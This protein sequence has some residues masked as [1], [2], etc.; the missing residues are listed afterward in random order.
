MPESRKRDAKERWGTTRQ[1]N[2]PNPNEITAPEN[3]QTGLTRKQIIIL[4]VVA[5]LFAGAIFYVVKNR[6]PRIEET[7]SGLQYQDYRIGDGPQPQKG[8]TVVVDYEGRLQR[9]NTKFDSSY[10]RNQPFE[11]KLGGGQ[12]IK[13]W[14]EGLAS[15][16]VGGKRRLIIP[17]KLGYGPQGQ[18][19]KIPGNS[20]LVFDVELKAIK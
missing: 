20:V 1:R 12:V 6:E 2:R 17:A 10:D 8:Q 13:G 18:P 16:K 11:F 5:A 15:M 14:D 9:G 19:P 7:A 3:R 4:A